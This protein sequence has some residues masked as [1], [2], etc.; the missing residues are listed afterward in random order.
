MDGLQIRYN[1]LLSGPVGQYYG[2]K[3][4]R[5]YRADE[6]AVK[7]GNEQPCHCH[8]PHDFPHCRGH[9]V[10]KPQLSVPHIP[11]RTPYCAR[12]GAR[13][14]VGCRK[15]SACVAMSICPCPCEP[16]R[17]FHGVCGFA[18]RSSDA[19]AFIYPHRLRMFNDRAVLPPAIIAKPESRHTG[20][21]SV[22]TGGRFPCRKTLQT[23][24]SGLL[25]LMF[26]LH[27][28]RFF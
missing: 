1:L 28:S 9:P 26:S 16:L 17:F 5:Q 19:I 7:T 10:R 21:T 27:Q 23:A 4:K 14:G 24:S 12:N 6:C 13:T 11:V 2:L 8:M 20:H 22:C 18:G 25:H 15:A 3:V